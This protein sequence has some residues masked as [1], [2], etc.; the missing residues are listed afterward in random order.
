ME[1]SEAS[2]VLTLPIS[3]NT[4]SARLK[5]DDRLAKA[6]IR[7]AMLPPALAGDGKS[8]GRG[9][10]WAEGVQDAENSE[11]C[12]PFSAAAYAHSLHPLATLSAAKYAKLSDLD[13]HIMGAM[14][15]KDSHRDLLAE[16]MERMAK[17]NDRLKVEAVR[18]RA[19][20]QERAA[21]T[22]QVYWRLYKERLKEQRK[23][24]KR[25][26]STW[27]E[28]VR[29]RR[30]P[31]H[32][33]TDGDDE[34]DDD[35]SDDDLGDAGQNDGVNVK[36]PKE[37]KPE[38]DK[39]AQEDPAKD[40]KKI[41]KSIKS[42]PEGASTDAAAAPG[43]GHGDGAGEVKKKRG[44]KKSKKGVAAEGD[45][46]P[47]G[48]GDGTNGAA[49][50]AVAA[51]DPG[52]ASGTGKRRRRNT[53]KKRA[54]SKDPE[55]EGG[56]AIDIAEGDEGGVPD[57][58]GQGVGPTLSWIELVAEQLSGDPA[59]G[60]NVDTA[61][62]VATAAVGTAAAHAADHVAVRGQLHTLDALEAD[63]HLEEDEE[64]E[65]EE[66]EEE[67]EDVAEDDDGI[68]EDEEPSEEF[69]DATHETLQEVQEG[70]EEEGGRG[71]QAQEREEGVL[72]ERGG[73]PIDAGADNDKDVNADAVISAVSEG[74]D[75]GQGEGKV[76]SD[77]GESMDAVAI[78]CS[79]VLE[80][81]DSAADAAVA[82]PAA[83]AAAA[84]E[85]AS[86]AAAGAA[87][88]LAAGATEAAARAA[89]RTVK[90][91]QRPERDP[92]AVQVQAWQPDLPEAAASHR[93]APTLGEH[94]SAR[95]ARSGRP[96]G[97]RGRQNSASGISAS[98]AQTL[99]LMQLQSD[100]R[101]IP[102]LLRI[103]DPTAAAV[104]AALVATA[105]S[106]PTTG[107]GAA[108]AAAAAAVAKLPGRVRA[109]SG[110]GYYSRPHSLSFLQILSPRLARLSPLRRI[111]HYIGSPPLSS[112]PLIVTGLK[113]SSAYEAS[114]LLRRAR[115][116][117]PAML[118]ELLDGSGDDSSDDRSVAGAFSATKL[119]LR[120]MRS[121]RASYS[122]SVEL[123]QTDQE[124]SEIPPLGGRVTDPQ[125]AL[126][127][128][129]IEQ[130]LGG[131]MAE[132]SGV[133]GVPEPSMEA[134]TLDDFSVAGG[135]STGLT[136]RG[137]SVRTFG[138]GAAAAGGASSVSGGSCSAP[139]SPLRGSTS[140][141]D[142]GGGGS[143]RFTSM[144]GLYSKPPSAVVSRQNPYRTYKQPTRLRQAGS[145]IGEAIAPRSGSTAVVATAATPATAAT[146]Q[147]SRSTASLLR[148]Q[149][150]QC[151]NASIVTPGFGDCEVGRGH[152]HL[153][154]AGGGRSGVGEDPSGFGLTGEASYMSLRS[155]RSMGPQLTA[156]RS[157]PALLQGTGTHA[158]HAFR[159]RADV[160]REVFALAHVDPGQLLQR[161]MTPPRGLR[162]K[163]LATAPP[164][165]PHH[166]A[167]H[168]VSPPPS[169]P[170]I[171]AV[172]LAQ[173][174]ADLLRQP[175]LRNSR[176][177]AQLAQQHGFPS[178][179]F[180]SL[181]GRQP[182]IRVRSLAQSLRPEPSSAKT[183]CYPTTTSYGL[184][185]PTVP[186][187]SL[188][189]A[190]GNSSAQAD[191]RFETEA[192]AVPEAT[193][194][195][196]QPEEL[197]VVLEVGRQ[198]VLREVERNASWSRGPSPGPG[199]EPRM[200]LTSQ[201]SGQLGG[202]LRRLS[203]PWATLGMSPSPGP[204]QLCVQG[205]PVLEPPRSPGAGGGARSPGGERSSLSTLPAGGGSGRVDGNGRQAGALLIVTT[206]THGGGYTADGS[207]GVGVGSPGSGAGI[208]PGTCGGDLLEG[209]VG[210][211]L[212]PP[213]SS[214]Q[215][216]SFLLPPR[217]RTSLHLVGTDALPQLRVGSARGPSRRETPSP[218]PIDAA[219]ARAE[220]AADL[221][222]RSSEPPSI[223][224]S[225][226][227]DSCC[228]HAESSHL[229]NHPAA[230]SC[231]T[232]FQTQNLPQQHDPASPQT[233]SNLVEADGEGAGAG[234][235]T[236]AE[237]V[238]APAGNG[239][240]AFYSDSEAAPL[241]TPL[242]V[243]THG[244]GTRQ[245][246]RD[247]DAMVT[248]SPTPTGR[249][250]SGR[251]AVPSSSLQGR[252]AAPGSHSAAAGG[253][254]SAASAAVGASWPPPISSPRLEAVGSSV[255][256]S[257]GNPQSPGALTAPPSNFVRSV[258][259]ASSI[260]GGGTPA[261]PTLPAAAAWT[262]A[263]AL[264]PHRNTSRSRRRKLSDQ[265]SHST[266]GRSGGFSVLALGSGQGFVGAVPPDRAGRYSP[267]G[268]L[269]G[270]TPWLQRV[271]PSSEPPAS[272]SQSSPA[273][274]GAAAA[275]AVVADAAG[276]AAGQGQGLGQTQQPTQL[277]Q[278]HTVKSPGSEKRM[279]SLE[280]FPA[281]SAARAVAAA[282]AAAAAAAVA[283]PAPARDT[284]IPGG[285]TSMAQ[286]SAVGGPAVS[287]TEEWPQSPLAGMPP[288]ASSS[289]SSAA[290]AMGAAYSTARYYD[291][292]RGGEGGGRSLPNVPPPP[293]VTTRLVVRRPAP[294]LRLP[295]VAA[296]QAAA[297]HNTLLQSRGKG[298][299]NT[300][301]GGSGGRSISPVGLMH[302]STGVA[303]N[304]Q[305]VVTH[306]NCEG[307][308]ASLEGRP[309][310]HLAPSPIVAVAGPSAGRSLSPDT[311]C[312]NGCD[313]S[314][315]LRA[316]QPSPSPSYMLMSEASKTS[317]AT[318]TAAA[319]AG[320]GGGSSRAA[321]RE[322]RGLERWWQAKGLDEAVVQ[323][324]R[325]PVSA[326]RTV[327]L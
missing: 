202:P 245:G 46:V 31:A 318:D 78:Q 20:N 260:G 326:P 178:W 93:R 199:Q 176:R 230:Q 231:S 18:L 54:K 56:G 151:V 243:R 186:P 201:L 154:G 51:A 49:A 320:G 322:W 289:P 19:A 296:A 39:P 157:A 299:P 189:P 145:T 117:E 218:A 42:K 269:L 270:P 33:G 164:G 104:A 103:I 184:I 87:A 203:D 167:H 134:V 4:R 81:A 108:I 61:T 63:S 96:D 286:G 129:D 233:A 90:R 152:G 47:R 106:S 105:P 86:N 220:A 275:V 288:S 32:S 67:E 113:A 131:M 267:Y 109:V 73:E 44:S 38:K 37:R 162:G 173:Q 272:Q 136:P 88:R 321:A 99:A 302:A 194:P 169:Q 72:S 156:E 196:P 70:Q 278:L 9:L 155:T 80:D 263:H 55:I 271:G 163:P 94:S 304:S 209:L 212:L 77:A 158:G 120:S 229:T 160:L 22:I 7:K 17:H 192:A 253:G 3:R 200:S 118:S 170:S 181:A 211:Q 125:M 159:H 293:S 198:L 48:T 305:L 276:H 135:A 315:S 312:Q 251:A 111:K 297:S 59:A 277:P 180:S 139:A 311:T 85:P 177:Y 14:E 60:Q 95:L 237:A 252:G 238:V 247:S 89:A 124:S 171:Q 292:Q 298:S 207:S 75:E 66:G 132:V 208:G 13:M 261:P 197:G 287:A 16:T 92:A 319:S 279:N 307:A 28:T 110:S 127:P 226:L 256:W 325:Q 115:S 91:H 116:S 219:A 141:V 232:Q 147:Y 58:D 142:G 223:A 214:C 236:A 98:A 228:E 264:T 138:S 35:V 183:D 23:Q 24:E 313:G 100:A 257:S 244:R 153:H 283:A 172:D 30:P 43:E 10:T 282:T 2:Y 235:A 191:P 258:T 301:T 266:G 204:A 102:S 1:D 217:T 84:A 224:A 309:S 50:A 306:V 12:R 137:G 248:D 8:P 123:S 213:P 76:Q 122:L 195:L 239:G 52:D 107:S 285:W 268:E 27:M 101:N 53:K 69:N 222:R 216:G 323:I 265:H 274:A 193:P 97:G 34:D 128:A 79:D 149:Q 15:H 71:G 11:R 143:G 74:E 255:P 175:N 294:V 29:R 300:A 148:S 187:P 284:T 140:V 166:V 308:P 68:Y 290:A 161:I 188:P 215:N 65:T 316:T 62:V 130:L 168:M 314:N 150:R 210:L 36:K 295:V 112:S 254:A 303:S 182:R 121:P 240:N 227:G 179:S 242:Q 221:Y 241:P 83:A 190:S 327:Y 234:G 21:R 249:S 246:G 259:G 119:L 280:V 26:T 144:T 114:P 6:A 317:M 281:K 41:K 25:R 133:V 206:T 64:Q 82:A 40:K 250:N 174:V 225:T 273:A 126:T 291:T 146:S 165:P 205:L 185:N 57:A 5:E 262:T 45:G 310:G 324:H